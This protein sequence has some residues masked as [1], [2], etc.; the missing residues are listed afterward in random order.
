[1]GLDGVEAFV[2]EH[3]LDEAGGRRIAVEGGDDIGAEGFAERGLV[4]ERLAESLPDQIARHVGMIEPLAD[5]VRD[6]VFERVAVQDVLVEKARQFRLA[7]G[8][9][10]GFLADAGPD[11][12]DLGEAF[13]GAR[14]MMSHDVVSW[15]PLVSPLR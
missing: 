4:V 5:A 12:I 6:R 15:S 1:M 10:F 13:G 8:D 3:R 14:L 9:I 7:A 2:I 11:R